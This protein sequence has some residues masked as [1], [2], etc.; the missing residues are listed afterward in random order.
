[1]IW[2]YDKTFVPLPKPKLDDSLDIIADGSVTAI[3]LNEKYKMGN[4]GSFSFN[5]NG[6]NIVRVFTVNG[7]SKVGKWS[8]G[9]Q[10]WEWSH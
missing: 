3:S 9:E 7:R 6:P 1:M 10:E 8:V 2:G 4:E 5:H